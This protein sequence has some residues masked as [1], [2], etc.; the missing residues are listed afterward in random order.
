MNEK[1]YMAMEEAANLAAYPETTQALTN[2][3][4]SDLAELC[5][6]QADS[7]DYDE[8]YSLKM[9]TLRDKLIAIINKGESK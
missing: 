5:D 2:D 7:F 4:L 9:A 3:E 1:H 6:A 8:A